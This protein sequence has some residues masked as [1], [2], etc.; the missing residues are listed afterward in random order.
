MS[1]IV[2]NVTTSNMVVN[3][4]LVQDDSLILLLDA[5]NP[6]SY[7]GSGNT[8]YDLS[9]SNDVNIA[10]NLCGDEGDLNCK[11]ISK[12]IKRQGFEL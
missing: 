3:P 4:K 11:K 2:T 9:G 8:W 12:E 1:R 6:K 10:K 5:E 7:P